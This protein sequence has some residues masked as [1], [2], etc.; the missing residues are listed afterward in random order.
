MLSLTQLD[1]VNLTFFA[2]DVMIYTSGDNI[3]ELAKN[4]IHEYLQLNSTVVNI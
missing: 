1:K 2:D 3:F 4:N